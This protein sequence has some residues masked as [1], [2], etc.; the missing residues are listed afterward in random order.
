MR[1]DYDKQ[2]DRKTI[3][4]PIFK[5]ASIGIAIGIVFITGTVTLEHN[6]NTFEQDISELKAQLARENAAERSLS[7]SD[8][9]QPSVR[10]EAVVAEPSITALVTNEPVTKMAVVASEAAVESRNTPISD[11]SESSIF[12]QV[13]TRS[14]S[15]ADRLVVGDPPATR[16]HGALND[17]MDKIPAAAPQLVTNQQ[18]D[19]AEVRDTAA[20]SDSVEQQTSAEPGAETL[21]RERYERL[22]HSEWIEQQRLRHEQWLEKIEQRHNSDINTRKAQ[23]RYQGYTANDGH[24]SI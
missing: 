9:E 7:K 23:H 18:P 4:G 21:E 16:E 17:P 2:A 6:V 8:E 19:A 13:M 15:K 10:T 5:Y 1:H 22:S 12:T 24:E 20:I 3:L 11:E 14:A